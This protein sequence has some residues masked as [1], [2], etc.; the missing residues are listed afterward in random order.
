[1][2]R[3]DSV[4]KPLMW[5]MALLL[6]VFAAG[7]SSGGGGSTAPSSAKAIT[8]YSLAGVAGVINETAKTITVAVPYGTNLTTAVATFTTSG[9][10][11]KVDTVVQTSGT[12]ANNLTNAVAYLV[13]AADGSTASYTVTAA[14]ARTA[15]KAFTAFSVA[16]VAGS[17]NETA[18]TIAVTVPNVTN[19]ASL[20]AAFTT[21]GSGV[22]VSGVTQTSAMSL[23]NFTSPVVYTVVAVDNT[24]AIYTVTVNKAAPDAK[25]I[26]SYSL[27]GVAGVIDEGSKAISVIMPNGTN[28]TTLV[29]TFTHTGTGSLTVASLSQVSGSTQNNFTA[30]VAYTVTAANFTTAT[31]TVTVSVAQNAAK[32]ITAY[33]LNSVAGTID[34]NAKTIT[35]TMP[36]GTNVSVLVASF[37]TTGTGVKVNNV[38]QTSG[39]TSNNFTTPVPYIVTAADTTT[40]TYTV[41]VVLAS[42]AVV[43][44]QGPTLCVDLLTA[45]NYAIFSNSAIANANASTITGNIAV[46]PGVTSTAITGFALT[47]P[48]ASPYSTSAL[49]SGRVY[50]KDYA[51]PTPADV[52]T[53]SNDMGTAYLDASGKTAVPGTCPGTGAFDGAVVPPLAAGVYTCAVAVNIPTNFTLNGSATDVWVFQITGTLDQA[54]GTQV[55]LTGGALPQNVFWR[56]S[57][58]VTVG[59]NAHFEGVLLGNTSITFGNLSSIK[60]RL[61]AKT[62][63]TLDQTAVVQP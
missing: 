25:S 51:N 54:A 43:C 60:G 10:S 59:A 29:A 63:I 30:P 27:A 56:V 12:T 13:T 53:A 4:T 18:R 1:M 48:A 19:L 23:N 5:F 21:T 40:A 24:T 52:N 44:T 2:N 50:A 36:S 17:I 31:Y 32:A 7:C 57:G 38:A 49:V 37:T 20:A 42:G 33:S 46:G 41:S 47:L 45:A 3:F 8:A 16:G 55:L 58:A 61:L 14:V 6:V 62:G 34:E 22:K 39:T 9:A 26:T 15:S 28:V 11:V 35:V